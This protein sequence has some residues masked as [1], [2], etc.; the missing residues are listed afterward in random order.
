[1]RV[2]ST[3]SLAVSQ[4]FKAIFFPSSNFNSLAWDKCFEALIAIMNLPLFP[5]FP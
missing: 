2:G 5:A 4:G 3:S 1:M